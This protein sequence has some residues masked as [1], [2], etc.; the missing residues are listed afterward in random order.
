MSLLLREQLKTEEGPNT[1]CVFPAEQSDKLAPAPL[2]DMQRELLPPASLTPASPDAHRH[3]CISCQAWRAM[4]H[5]PPAHVHGSVVNSPRLL[6]HGTLGFLHH[7]S[8]VRACEG[9]LR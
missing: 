9:A 3:T 5:P 6:A 7:W 4:V 1:P 8:P 2:A